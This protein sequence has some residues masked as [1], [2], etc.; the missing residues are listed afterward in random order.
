M[1]ICTRDNKVRE[2][3]IETNY[4][5][6]KEKR[7]DNLLNNIKDDKY[8]QNLYRAKKNIIIEKF[9]F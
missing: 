1:L 3:K 7:D 6:M 8:N 5:E 2:I 4:K 9:N